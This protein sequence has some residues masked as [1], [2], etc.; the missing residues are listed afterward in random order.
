MLEGGYY[1][2]ILLLQEQILTFGKLELDN[3][4]HVLLDKRR[5]QQISYK[6]SDSFIK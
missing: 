1:S 5:K 6:E 2:L 3:Y 4:R